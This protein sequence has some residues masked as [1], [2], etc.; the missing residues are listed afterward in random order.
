MKTTIVAIVVVVYRNIRLKTCLD[1]PCDPSGI[2]SPSYTVSVDRFVS[3]EVVLPDKAEW[4]GRSIKGVLSSVRV[5]RLVPP[6]KRLS[7]RRRTTSRSLPSKVIWSGGRSPGLATGVKVVPL[8]T[9]PGG[10]VTS[11]RH[12]GH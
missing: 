10:I 12:V 4:A 1:S 5:L 2:L 3:L 6:G 9:S 11:A 7:Q 8:L